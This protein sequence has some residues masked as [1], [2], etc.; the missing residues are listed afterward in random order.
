MYIKL[1]SCMLISRKSLEEVIIEGLYIQ[2]FHLFIW[3]FVR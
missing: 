2:L 1:A 3:T